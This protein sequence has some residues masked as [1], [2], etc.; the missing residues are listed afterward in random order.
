[1]DTV[2]VILLIAA[3]WG[4]G[5]LFGRRTRAG[6][7]AGLPTELHPKTHDEPLED[8]AKVLD[9]KRHGESGINEAEEYRDIRR[10]L[11]GDR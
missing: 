9:E 11:G 2:L 6:E 5:V 1:M 10:N 3:A 8:T 7:S 4:L